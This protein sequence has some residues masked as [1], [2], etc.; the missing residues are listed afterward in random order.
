M[1][2]VVEPRARRLVAVTGWIHVV[3]SQ[4][5]KHHYRI[6]EGSGSFL[7][8]CNNGTEEAAVRGRRA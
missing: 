5:R 6:E 2:T 1:S 3:T 7:V 8:I 4:G